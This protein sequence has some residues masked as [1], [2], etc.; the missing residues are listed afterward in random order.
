MERCQDPSRVGALQPATA[1]IIEAF[2]DDVHAG[3]IFLLN[4]PYHGGSHLPDVTVFVPVFLGESLAFWAVNRAHHSDIG[5]ATYDT[6]VNHSMMLAGDVARLLAG[7][8]PL[9]CVN[10]EVL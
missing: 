1:A 10:P 3:D 7:E 5:G 4:D 6:E 2:A 8:R 9:H